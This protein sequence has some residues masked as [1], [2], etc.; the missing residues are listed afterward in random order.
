MLYTSEDKELLNKKGISESKIEAQLKNFEQGFPF[1][2]LRAAASVGN[3]I[4]APAVEEAEKY[5]KVWND[6]KA[7][8]HSITK[9]VP[10]S[11]AASRMFKNMFE[12]LN[13]DYDVPTTEFEKAFFADIHKF[14]FFDV[15]NDFTIK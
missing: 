4:I 5:V 15:L 9:F 6:Y 7:E 2:K 12:F 13:S 14:A 3:G 10:A 11:G 1:L 8:G